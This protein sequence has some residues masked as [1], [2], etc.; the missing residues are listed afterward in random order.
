MSKS[1]GIPISS[2]FA[3]IAELRKSYIKRF[4]CTLDYD[5]MGFPVRAHI[6]IQVR[7]DDKEKLAK[8]LKGCISCNSVYKV[9]TDY[10]YLLICIF[11]NLNC[12]EDF[13]EE[14]SASFKVTKKHVCYLV[15]CIKEEGFLSDSLMQ[16][17]AGCTES[18]SQ[19]KHGLW[20]DSIPCER[21]CVVA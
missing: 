20:K 9:T 4:I 12:M 17:D 11:A 13:L 15:E 1:T 5:R 19:D 18:W 8:Y 7:K 16:I 3:K 21:G 2:V 6:L 10:D 14:V